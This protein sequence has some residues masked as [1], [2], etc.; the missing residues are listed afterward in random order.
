MDKLQ[1]ESDM[2]TRDLVKKQATLDKQM[3]QLQENFKCVASKE[4]FDNLNVIIQNS[5]TSVDLEN[6]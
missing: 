1:S 6:V 4:D 5:V 2:V 3:N